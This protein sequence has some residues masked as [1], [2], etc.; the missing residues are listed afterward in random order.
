[1]LIF[2]DKK[3][4]QEQ[5][6]GLLIMS[7]GST[8]VEVRDPEGLQ[9]EEFIDNLVYTTVFAE[10]QALKSYAGTVVRNIAAQVGI[11][12]ASI[13]A[14]YMAF[15]R[16]DLSGF[17]VPA[18][19]LRTMTFDMARAALR[20]K[21]TL[22]AGP[23]L[24]E[25]ARSEMGYTRQT[26]LE[27]ATSVLGAAIKEHAADGDFGPLLIQGDHFKVLPKNFR[28]NRTHELGVLKNLINDAIAARFLNIDIDTSTLV[29]L[30]KEM[31]PDQQALNY[32]IS[33]ELI[34]H[35]RQQ[36]P[37][38]V[39][40]S[41]GGEIGEVGEQESTTEELRAYMDGMNAELER[42]SDESD[43]TPLAGP[44]KISVNSGT[45][46]GGI[47]REDGTLADMH[48]DFD[49]LK[50][51]SRIA[52]EEYGMAGVV[53][54]GA[55]TLSE[56]LY[57]KFPESNTVEVHLAAAFQNIIYDHEDF[58]ETL[59]QQMYD[60]VRQNHAHERKEEWSDEQF[61]YKLRKK[62]FGPFKKQLWEVDAA[63]KSRIM[64]SLEATFHST[65]RELGMENT[66]EITRQYLQEG[67]L[68]KEPS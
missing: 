48:P 12:P 40:I 10:S 11:Y 67:A 35:L 55:S 18:I 27:Y 20:A 62:G 58:P 64:G 23:V 32:T 30:S 1:M 36:S 31:V 42:L 24:F 45:V 66:G 57:Y 25:S 54:H 21:K 41:V 33:A 34:R 60:Y 38:G 29:D 19:N 46:H 26:P 65:F 17:T 7:P 15:S 59:R 22:N 6:A 44:S 13:Q 2:E 61:I 9:S 52:R 16:G 43:G 50:E 28:E 68:R 3:M 4:I 47:V 37:A 53:Q 51:M 5:A 8:E 56:D 39:V 14:L 49:L 63:R